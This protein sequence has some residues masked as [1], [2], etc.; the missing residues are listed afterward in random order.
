MQVG[1]FA[2]LAVEEGAA[3]ALGLGGLAVEPHVEVGDQ[4]AAPFE[5]VEQR[6]TPVSAR[7]RDRGIHL[8]H[9]ESP[10]SRRDRVAFSGVGLLPNSVGVADP[11]SP[12]TGVG[13]GKGGAEALQL[14]AG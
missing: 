14:I 1:E 11:A 4:L 2:N 9:R 10:T 8:H 6:D 12:W 3:L 5:H 7:Q 13:A